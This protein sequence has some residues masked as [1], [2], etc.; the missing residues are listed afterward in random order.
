MAFILLPPSALASPGDLDASFGNSGMV[1]TPVGASEEPI[2]AIAQ[3]ADGKIVVV[4]AGQ[5]LRY[6]T[7]GSLDTSFDG[8]GKVSTE[9]GGISIK[10]NTVAVQADGK[11]AIAGTA[12]FPVEDSDFA[13]ARYDSDGSPDAGFGGD[14]L[15]TTDISDGDRAHDVVIQPDGKIVVAGQS[16][17]HLGE[18]SPD[19][20]FALV[21]YNADGSLDPSFDGDGK[22]TTDFGGYIDRA[23]A[24]LL[25][26]DGKL[27]AVGRAIN[28]STVGGFALARYNP[29]GSLDPTFGGGDGLSVQ[30]EPNLQAVAAALQSNGRIVVAGS[31]GG[32]VFAVARFTA[33]GFLDPSFGEGD[34]LTVTRFPLPYDG[35]AYANA[36]L[37]QPDGRIIA[38]G[39]AY[40]EATYSDDFAVA[41]YEFNG[42]LD[43]SFGDKGMA[44][45]D[46]GGGYSSYIGAAALQPDGR[47]IAG[48]AVGAANFALARYEGGG[49]LPAPMPAYM[50]TVSRAGVGSGSIAISPAASICEPNCEVFEWGEAV[51]LTAQAVA[52]STFTGWTGGGCSGVGSCR[53]SMMANQTVT[54]TFSLE[55]A[56][57][58]EDISPPDEHSQLPAGNSPPSPGVAQTQPSSTAPV[59]HK[60]TKKA[61]ARK[62]AV[63]H[64]KKLE[65]KAKRRCLR[66]VRRRF[67]K[68]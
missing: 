41:R 26:P 2:N 21:R 55:G 60:S 56:S 5:L 19:Y 17:T 64:C 30:F 28:A 1:T 67:S 6:D 38:A 32:E 59:K 48:G 34:G 4:G 50:L 49:S 9:I 12:M 14:G 22:L 62:R 13:V 23:R 29:D 45:T 31:W 52:G 61:R 53:I 65:G 57:G 27:I 58:E 25:Q 16:Y 3:Q 66:N 20:D 46:F 68:S 47:L 43:T 24:L 15:V 10:A 63:M 37:V 36:V 18:Y 35:G 7:D 8:D 39:G 54:A 44:T 11:I 40:D 33:D 51:T 42:I